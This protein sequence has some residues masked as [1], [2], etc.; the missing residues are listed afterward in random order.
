MYKEV[1]RFIQ[2]NTINKGKKIRMKNKEITSNMNAQDIIN[3]VEKELEIK[4]SYKEV[5][6]MIEEKENSQIELA[7]E[8]EIVTKKKFNKKKLALF[9]LPILAIGLVFAA[10]LV[11]YG[12]VQ[13]NMTIESPVVFNGETESFELV[14]LIAGDGYRLYLVEG[15]NLLSR[16]V[17][18]EFQF[19]LLNGTG[20]P[21]EDTTGFY[22]AYSDDIQYAYNPE[23]GNVSNWENAQIWMFANLDWFD[24]M[25][26]G[27]LSDY[28]SS[29][30]TDHGGNSAHTGL[31]FNTKYPEDLEPG[32]FYV[33]VYL[34]VDE[35]VIP[36]DYTLSIDMMPVTA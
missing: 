4:H 5:K 3:I 24:W 16:D 21:L 15:E 31:E 22:L 30:I 29:I 32:K 23:Y 18:V 1:C 17:D 8:K 26:K 10:V 11:Y 14:E 2:K 12:Q 25:I 27:D 33:V 34:D 9:I 19:S 20:S 36:G 13:V 35:A 6:N 28:N 7:T